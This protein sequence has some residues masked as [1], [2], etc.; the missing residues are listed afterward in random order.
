MRFVNT[1]PV[2]KHYQDSIE[3]LEKTQKER[4]DS[5]TYKGKREAK[6][7]YPAPYCACKTSINPCVLSIKEDK[8]PQK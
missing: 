7:G 6:L 8:H 1:F 5:E 2:F 3:T 4:K